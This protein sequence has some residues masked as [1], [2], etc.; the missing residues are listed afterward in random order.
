NAS[1]VNTETLLQCQQKALMLKSV[2]ND[3]DIP[4]IESRCIKS[5]L[6]FSQFGHA[7][8]SNVSRNFYLINFDE[9]EVRILTM[10]DWRTCKS[11]HKKLAK[12]DKVYC[13][14]S[15]QLLM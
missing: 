5:D 1:F 15:V 6:Q 3:S 7:A 14:S 9:D 12:Q 13:S 2:F 11:Q 10:P 4:V 8:T